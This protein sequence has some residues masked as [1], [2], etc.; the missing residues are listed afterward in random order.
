MIVYQAN[1]SGFIKDIENRGIEYQIAR[2]YLDKTGR[3]AP[4]AELRAWRSSLQEMA[5]VLRD[6]GIPDDTGIGVEFGIPQTSKR[7]DFLISGSTAD[8]TPHLIIVELKQWSSSKLSVKDGIVVAQRGGP[9][10]SEGPHPC[11]QAWSYAAL[12][13]GFNEA[14]HEGDVSL[15]ACAYLHNYTDDG[16][17]THPHY[18]PYIEKA[19][20]FLKGNT[21][22]ER[23]RSFIKQHVKRGD[24]AELLY[25]IENG[26]IRPSK[27][28][29]DSLVKMLR[30]SREF[31]LIDEQKLVYE[32]AL[33]AA[34]TASS[35][36][37]QVVLVKGGPGT[38]K[39]VVAINLLVELTRLGLLAKYVSKNAAPRAVYKER[40]RGNFKQVEIGNL[41]SGSGGFIETAPDTFDAL[42]VDEAHRLNRHS[43]LYGNLG[44]NQVKELIQSAKCTILFVDDDQMVTLADIGHSD[45]IRHWANELGASVTELELASQFRCSGSDGY[46]AWIDN[47][48]GIRETANTSLDHGDF[49]FRVIDSPTE[50]HA[51]IAEK[52]RHNNRSRVVAGYCWDWE[53]KKKPEAYDIVIPE[54]GY[55]RQWNLDKDGSLWLIAPESID[56]VGCI[57]TCQ[58]LE[59]DYVGVIIGPDM[60]FQNH[61]VQTDPSGRSK[62][63]RSIRGYKK[64]V[65]SDREETRK[66]LDRI[67]RN[68][69]RTLMTRGMKGCYVYCTDPELQAHLSKAIKPLAPVVL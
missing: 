11:Y 30:G 52:N 62:Q 35:D 25:R 58:G 32:T 66:R 28:L 15:K 57:H 23:L 22:R 65:Q 53:S 13:E 38:G 18:A 12:L 31:I 68:T 48:L 45:E 19:P 26:R 46:L 24:N 67:I 10:E 55:Q 54:F 50:L 9:R 64:M 61:T 29:A 1:K 63:D 40:L 7:I 42:V 27:M 47:T 33:A 14:V 59:L 49:D 34:R 17:I 51:L 8:G 5:S 44:E 41:F 37:K 20:I 4:D 69:Y 39:S 36:A 16:I 43:G 56:E 3:Y 60:V 2:T 21:E 6:D